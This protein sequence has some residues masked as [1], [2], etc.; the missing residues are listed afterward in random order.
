MV[1]MNCDKNKGADTKTMQIMQCL[2]TIIQKQPPSDDEESDTTSS[3]CERVNKK[4]TDSKVDDDSSHGTTMEDSIIN[5]SP[6]IISDSKDDDDSS[7]DEIIENSIISE[8]STIISNSEDIFPIGKYPEFFF[9]TD[10]GGPI[11]WIRQ[12]DGVFI[13]ELNLECAV[14]KRIKDFIEDGLKTHNYTSPKREATR[15]LIAQRTVDEFKDRND[16]SA[17]EKIKLVNANKRLIEGSKR[18]APLVRQREIVITKIEAVYNK[19]LYE[20]F[21]RFKQEMP[22]RENPLGKVKWSSE[23]QIIIDDDKGETFLL[24]GT[25]PNHILGIISNG[26][27]PSIYCKN[28]HESEENATADYGML[29]QATCFADLL[30]KAMTY[31]RCSICGDYD[32]DGTKCTEQIRSSEPNATIEGEIGHKTILARVLL[33]HPKKMHGKLQAGGSLRSDDVH[34]IKLHRDS[35]YSQGI[36]EA[37]YNWFRAGSSLNEFGIKKKEQ[38]YPQFIISWKYKNPL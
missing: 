1:K 4:E 23:K 36:R 37:S 11:N 20:S 25:L 33:G 18:G 8:S 7:Y 21:Q 31:S 5:A 38:M 28:R 12:E 19:D 34:M 24:H 26:F 17:Q 15:M 30:S 6:T 32:C 14:S 2:N 3:S 9:N 13:A 22:F 27:D 35:I 29:G 16:L 10:F